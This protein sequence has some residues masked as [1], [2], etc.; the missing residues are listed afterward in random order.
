MY[1]FFY[2]IISALVVSGCHSDNDFLEP[3][4][5]NK[6]K[7][8]ESELYDTTYRTVL[9]FL[10]ESTNSRNGVPDY[11]FDAAQPILPQ[12][13]Q[14]SDAQLDTLYKSVVTDKDLEILSEEYE[15]LLSSLYETYGY[16][17]VG[18]MLTCAEEYAVAG[19]GKANASIHPDMTIPDGL[20]VF[21]IRY[22]ATF[23]AVVGDAWTN[24]E[25]LFS[26]RDMLGVELCGMAL[27][28]AA[29]VFSG[30]TIVIGSMSDLAGIV[31]ALAKYRWCMRTG[32]FI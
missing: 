14:Y 32:Q 27:V 17:N 3:D 5:V 22:T 15:K 18:L 11:E 26:C 20:R 29:D 2:A 31:D 24:M 19:G 7:I 1:K 12:L 6:Q 30:G 25:P 23:D 8:G 13:M 21:Y 16:D 28:I 10:A 9:A 4:D